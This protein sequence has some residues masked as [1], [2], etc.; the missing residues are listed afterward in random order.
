MMHPACGPYCAL[1]CPYCAPQAANA[2]KCEAIR[3]Q[4]EGGLAAWNGPLLLDCSN[5]LGNH[6]PAKNR[7]SPGVTK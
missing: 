7:G 6:Y 2:V 3:R 1:L 5:G 4:T